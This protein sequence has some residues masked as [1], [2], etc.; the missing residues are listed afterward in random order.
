M[1]VTYKGSTGATGVMGRTG[2]IGETGS[3]G[4]TGATCFAVA[5]VHAAKRR[6]ERA[7]PQG[8]PGNLI[9]IITIA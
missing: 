4:D 3:T 8:C 5:E 6:V 7:L 1:F 9:I 2:V